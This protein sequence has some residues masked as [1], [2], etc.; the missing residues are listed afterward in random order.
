[1]LR[2]RARSS[3]AA[4]DRCVVELAVDPYSWRVPWSTP[5]ARYAWAR[6]H[7]LISS[8]VFSTFVMLFFAVLV[9]VQGEL[10][11]R[12]IPV[13]ALSIAVGTIAGYLGQRRRWGQRPDADDQPLPTRRRVWT[14]TSDGALRWWMWSGLVGSV[15]SLI[16][17]VRG[18]RLVSAAVGL[19]AG[20]CLVVTT[21]G[22]QARRRTE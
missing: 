19:V 9:A 13:A 6:R 21:R 22:E 15:L 20:A 5:E 18:A 4:E 1:M 16:D 12:F 8:L 14:R 2:R 3:S 10:D 11:V 17:L 7:P